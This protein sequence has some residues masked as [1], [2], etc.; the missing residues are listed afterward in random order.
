MKKK[1]KQTIFDNFIILKTMKYFCMNLKFSVCYAFCILLL[2]FKAMACSDWSFILLTCSAT[3][4]LLH[5]R[6]FIFSVEPLVLLANK[7][8]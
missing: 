2:I 8:R 7:T 6:Q 1:K 4:V 5:W 3:Q